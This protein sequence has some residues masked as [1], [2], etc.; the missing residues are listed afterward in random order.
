MALAPPP[1][2]LTIN[3]RVRKSSA[4]ALGLLFGFLGVLI[5]SFWLPLSRLAMIVVARRARITPA[6]LTQAYDCLLYT[7]LRGME[8][9]RI[10]MNQL[11]TGARSRALASA[12]ML[13]LTACGSRETG[14]IN[15]SGSTS[16]SPFV[17]HLAELYERGHSGGA[18]N[19]QSLGSTAGI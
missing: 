19:V 17:E 12:L 9:P 4:D 2:A 5:F 3:D 6:A 16:V 11:L 10:T 14:G 1:I 13:L 8:R 18:L 15:I 7:A